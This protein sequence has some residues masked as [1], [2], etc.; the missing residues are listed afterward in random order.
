MRRE[1]T[2]TSSVRRY[3]LCLMRSIDG[4]SASAGRRSY[5]VISCRWT[6]CGARSS[7]EPRSCRDHVPAAATCRNSLRDRDDATRY[8]IILNEFNNCTF[9]LFAVESD[10]EVGLWNGRA[11]VSVTVA[12]R[13]ARSG[14][15]R[16][17]G[18]A[19]RGSARARLSLAP[20]PPA[21]SPRPAAAAACAD[22]ELNVNQVDG[23][24]L[25]LLVS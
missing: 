7:Q 2:L 13:V 12:V 14:A 18:A 11:L 5:C 20:P 8:R 19:G 10:S 6:L 1:C 25:F 16:G 9:V 22:A 24:H 4:R 21:T 3:I 17:A 15:V 23:R